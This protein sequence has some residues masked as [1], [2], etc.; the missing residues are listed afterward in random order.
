MALFVCEALPE[1]VK[2]DRAILL[3]AAVSPDYNL[4]PAM[5]HCTLGIVNFYSK[6]DWF[7]CGLLAEIFG[8]MDR[9]YTSTAGKRGLVAPNGEFATAENLVQIAWTPGW[10]G[11]TATPTSAQRAVLKIA[12]HPIRAITSRSVFMVGRI[13]A[14]WRTSHAPVTASRQLAKM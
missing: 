2:V 14:T 9:K 8:T 11:L 4:A 3:A 5:D 1:D 13:P 10:R 12:E 6:E 7:S